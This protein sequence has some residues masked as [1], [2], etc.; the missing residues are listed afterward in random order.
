MAS[1][2]GRATPFTTRLDVRAGATVISSSD[3]SLFASVEFAMFDFVG[4]WGVVASLPRRERRAGVRDA[5]L[6][7]ELSVAKDLS[8]PPSM[9]HG[10]SPK[11]TVDGVSWR[12]GCFASL[13]G[14]GSF[15]SRH[16]EGMGFLKK[17]D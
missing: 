15:G 9:W 10:R 12:T 1:I 6:V 16:D 11:R 17:L 2:C 4:F 14:S 5:D 13:S 3:V 8:A 7:E